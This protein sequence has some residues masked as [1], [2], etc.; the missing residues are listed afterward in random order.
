MLV[1]T[2]NYVIFLSGKEKANGHRWSMITY[3]IGERIIFSKNYSFEKSLC[4]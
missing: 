4:G 3:R 2:Q 1:T